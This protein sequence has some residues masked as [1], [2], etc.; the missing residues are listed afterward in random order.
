MVAPRP[1]TVTL[2]N[3]QERI[4]HHHRDRSTMT[5]FCRVFTLLCFLHLLM[6]GHLA[7][8][9]APARSEA[10]EKPSKKSNRLHQVRVSHSH[11]RWQRLFTS[12]Y[13]PKIKARNT[14]SSCR[15]RRI[16]LVRMGPMSI[17]ATWAVLLL[18]SRLHLRLPDVRESAVGR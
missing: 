18:T 13:V 10:A 3:P 14:R 1:P 16:A 9:P 15:A 11:A 2:A 6:P 12:V 4:V 7:A 5:L 17:A 8:Q